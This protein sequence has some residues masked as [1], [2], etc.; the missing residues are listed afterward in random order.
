MVVLRKF[1]ILQSLSILST[2][3]GSSVGNASLFWTSRIQTDLFGS[4][5]F[6]SKIFALCLI[7]FS[8]VIFSSPLISNTVTTTSKFFLIIDSI[9]VFL[10]I[11]ARS[12][13]SSFLSI[14]LLVCP[15]RRTFS[16]N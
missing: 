11:L 2:L 12:L 5:L 16:V 15:P 9:W 8:Q 10:G 13:N 3:C 14:C 4:N 1:L 6:G 7:C